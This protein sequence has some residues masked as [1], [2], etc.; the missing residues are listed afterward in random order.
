MVV[1]KYGALP[2]GAEAIDWQERINMP[3]MREERAARTRKMM[4]DNGFPAMILFNADTRRYSTSVHPGVLGGLIPGVAGL[5]IIFAE[6][7]TADIIDY[8]LEGNLTRQ[9]RIHCTWIKPENQRT[10]YSLAE[11]QGPE[12]VKEHAKKQAKEIKQV[13]EEKGLAKE[14]IAYDS[15]NA[16]MMSALEAEGLTL[17]PVGHL[18]QEMRATKTQDEID[19]IRMGG[20]FGDIAWGVMFKELRPGITERELAG[21]MSHAIYLKQQAGQPLISLRSGPNSAPNWLSHSPQD[22]VISPGDLVICDL[23]L[24]GY[25]GYHS[26]YYRTFKCG[27]KPT[28]KEKDW[29]KQCYEWL[30][31]ACEEIKPG[32]TTADA[33]KKFPPAATWGYKEEYECWSNA[34]G[35][36][37]GLSSYELPRISRCCSLDY[38]QEIRK[39]MTIAM[40]TWMGEDGHGGVRIEN[41]GVVTDNGWENLYQW[42]DEEIICPSHQLIF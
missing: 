32:K 33:A 21:K 5:S 39:G 20:A 17:V 15:S 36:G 37:L 7:P 14:K 24:C 40:E 18:I 6:L 9:N 35:H 30:Y 31:N 23:I 19:C 16:A 26:C 22:R 34:L 3:R 4:K 29:Y 2:W 11:N 10:V 28:E 38:P 42:P 41:M 8:S 1:K 27:T 25:S 13:L 12:I